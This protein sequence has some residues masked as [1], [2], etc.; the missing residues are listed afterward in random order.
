MPLG[1]AA[2][3]EDQT[4][5]RGPQAGAFRM[6]LAEQTVNVKFGRKCVTHLPLRVMGEYLHPLFGTGGV[7]RT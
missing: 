2:A 1:G 4:A 5:F 3:V 7:K 6:L